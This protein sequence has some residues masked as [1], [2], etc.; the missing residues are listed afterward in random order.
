MMRSFQFF[1]LCTTDKGH[2]FAPYVLTWPEILQTDMFVLPCVIQSPEHT[3]GFACPCLTV[4]YSHSYHCLTSNCQD[5][6]RFSAVS[7]VS[8]SIS[9]SSLFS[10][11]L[12]TI[13]LRFFWF[14]ISPTFLFFMF[15]S[16]S[17][18]LPP[19]MGAVQE[20]DVI[21]ILQ[22]TEFTVICPFQANICANQ[23]FLRNPIHRANK[24]GDK[25]RP[26]LT[27]VMTLT[28]LRL[29]HSI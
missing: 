17:H 24:T 29:C 15:N 28:T 26:C 12:D 10:E 8:L 19:V 14:I 13:S 3:I 7:T 6:K 1:F 27:H 5:N 9:I 18:S 23:C 21:S 22:V 16:H 25:I 11:V 2:N 4:F 20:N